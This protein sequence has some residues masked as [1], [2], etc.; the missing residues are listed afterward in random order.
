MGHELL[1]NITVDSPP[2]DRRRLQSPQSPYFPKVKWSAE[3]AN[4]CQQ[5][6]QKTV[7]GFWGG[8]DICDFTMEETSGCSGDPSFFFTV[9]EIATFVSE[10]EPE[11]VWV[12]LHWLFCMGAD[13][14]VNNVYNLGVN[15]D[16]EI[17]CGASPD[18]IFNA[19]LD[20]FEFNYPHIGLTP[21]DFKKHKNSVSQWKSLLD[22]VERAESRPGQAAEKFHIKSVD[23]KELKL[24]QKQKKKAPEPV[25]IEPEDE[26]CADCIEYLVEFYYFAILFT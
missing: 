6:I 8:G 1:A 25:P 4:Q 13:C 5:C 11:V 24:K 26:Q 7:T 14:C 20:T 10:Q 15:E 3:P 22:K 12:S 2:L 18:A 23:V 19:M 21:A 16:P 9:S 17:L